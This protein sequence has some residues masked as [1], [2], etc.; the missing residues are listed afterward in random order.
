ML[1]KQRPRIVGGKKLFACVK[2][3][4]KR[5]VSVDGESRVSWKTFAD[6]FPFSCLQRD[7]E[8]FVM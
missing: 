1:C 3:D 2:W 4:E 5:Q 6:R 7:I 8:A